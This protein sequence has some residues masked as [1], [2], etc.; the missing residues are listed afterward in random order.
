MISTDGS[1]DRPEMGG[2][3]VGGY[4]V[5]FA[6]Q[7]ECNVSDF[8]PMAEPQTIGRAELLAVLKAVYAVTMYRKTCIISDSEYVVNGCNGWAARWR[9]NK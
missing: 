6:D 9:R 3:W 1:S 4:G 2:D 7:P 8:I 5:C